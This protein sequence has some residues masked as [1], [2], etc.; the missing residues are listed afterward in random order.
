[1]KKSIVAILL[2]FCMGAG[3]SQ[4]RGMRNIVNLVSSG[5]LKMSE[6]SSNAKSIGIFEKFEITFDLTGEWQNPFDP[7]QIKVDAYF[8]G[9]DGKKLAVPGF[10]YQEYYQKDN[11][12]IEKIGNP[13]WKVRFAPSAPGKYTYKVVANNSGNEASSAEG[14]FTCVSFAANRGF[15][16]I[17]NTN[18]LYFEYSDGTTFFGRAMDSSGGDN[19][20]SYERFAQAGGNLNRLFPG[21]KFNIQEFVGKTPRPDWGLGKM[22]LEAAWNLDKILE[23]GEKLGIYQMIT[24]TNQTGFNGAWASHV[25]NKANGGIL[26]SKDQ[27][28]TNEQAAKIFEARLRY[29]VARYNHSTSL[30]SYDLWNEYSVMSVNPKNAADVGKWH[31]RMARYM[32]SIDVYGHMVHTNDGYLNGGYDEVHSL[33]EMEIISTNIYATK[34]NAPMAETWTKYNI[35]KYKKPYLLTEY[36][37]GHTGRYAEL[38]PERRMVHNGLWATTLSGSAGT[39]MAWDWQWLDHETFYTYI[40]AIDKFVTD[41]PFS[42]RQ[43]APVTVS[44]FKFGKSKPAYYSDVAFE[45][46]PTNF[47]YRPFR[48]T[49]GEQESFTIDKNGKVKNQELLNAILE[50]SAGN[51]KASNSSVNFKVE[52]PSNGKFVAYLFP[53][54]ITFRPG[55]TPPKGPVPKLVVS[56]DG[57]QL[58]V[59]EL[60]SLAIENYTVD[61]PKGAHAITVANTGGGSFFTCFELKNYL[62]RQGPDLDVR[63]MQADDYILLW[64]LNPKYEWLH[65]MQKISLESQP[66]GVLELQNV[67]NGTWVAEWINTIDAS[68]VKTE[69]VKSD[70][71]KLVLN[72]PVVEKSVAVRLTKMKGSLASAK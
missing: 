57:K 71:Q 54:D 16:R 58:L 56:V 26:D 14:E 60:P 2:L 24:V 4:D 65:E 3:Y 23:L 9:P 15:I 10:F 50:G 68:V 20:G 38:D 37:V 5:P 64:L 51:P 63:G 7:D 49:L 59:K 6:L 11:G 39:G 27:M 62:L 70:K 30:F 72:T 8:T 19:N 1:M 45:G 44:S 36:G 22:N 48:E 53:M 25:Y 52:Y 31:Q 21:G 69:V 12:E 41:V 13:V 66:E 28:W 34:I 67:S 33:P 61:V 35:S 29:Y 47:N 42:K 55:N 40:K 17:S 43:W 46:W 32:K 18:P